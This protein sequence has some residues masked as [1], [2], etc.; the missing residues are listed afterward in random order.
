MAHRKK[1]SSTVITG[2]NRLSISSAI[3]GSEVENILEK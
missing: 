3:G 2:A 1:L